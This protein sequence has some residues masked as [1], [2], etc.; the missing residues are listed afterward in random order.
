MTKHVSPG[1]HILLDMWNAKHMTDL[2]YV[3][4]ALT[5]AATSCGL[6]ILDVHLHH[7]GED[8]GAGVTGVAIL[9]ESHISIH[10]WPE[11]DYMAIDIFVC[12][13]ADPTPAISSLKD[14]FQ[15]GS[16]SLTSQQRGIRK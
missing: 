11:I 14:D 15:P 3:G 5:K 16:F 13:S 1:I 10:T 12:G 4:N 7:F 9:A 6:T 2:T 8:E